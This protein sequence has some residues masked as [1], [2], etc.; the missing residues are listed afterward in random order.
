MLIGFAL[1]VLPLA[2]R[3]YH[4]LGEFSIIGLPKYSVVGEI[5]PYPDHGA[6]RSLNRIS[7]FSVFL[8][9]PNAVLV[10]YL[11]GLSNNLTALFSSAHPLLWGLFLIPLLRYRREVMGK[12]CL[13][14]LFILGLLWLNFSM[15][16][17]EGARFY[18]PVVPLVVLGGIYG[19]RHLLTGSSGVLE[20]SNAKHW[21]RHWIGLGFLFLL[22]LPG[23][24][25]LWQTALSPPDGIFRRNLELL[26]ENYIP[27]DAVVAS[28]TP[29]ATGWYGE[30]LSIWLP[31]DY[32]QIET[33]DQR[34]P[35]DYVVLTPGVGSADWTGTSWQR[36]YHTGNNLPGYRCVFP[37]RRPGPVLIFEKVSD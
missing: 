1:V 12:L 11:K 16:E 28:D 23:L 20:G 17:F 36:I 3:N 10:K 7:V 24:L 9:N 5:P 22:I 2:L 33:L 26:I 13:F 15:G 37:E 8:S 19:L 32:K 21:L 4:Y 35:I 14:S 25:H 34:L 29:W 18:E 27:E 6:E 31:M 30:R